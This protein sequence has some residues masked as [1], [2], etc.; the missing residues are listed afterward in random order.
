MLSVR[1]PF[2]DPS[3]PSQNP[4]NRRGGRPTLHTS[5][6]TAPSQSATPPLRSSPL[7]GWR[8]VAS[9]LPAFEEQQL[10]EGRGLIN[11]R[12]LIGWRRGLAAYRRRLRGRRGVN[13][14][15]P[16]IARSAEA[17]EKGG[18]APELLRGLF[19][20]FPVLGITK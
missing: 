1:S 2:P 6:L 3:L 17:K 12:R 13:V 8:H 19:P 5:P 7:I 20:H 18:K 10:G 15:P 14:A 16:P 4:L 11:L 9:R